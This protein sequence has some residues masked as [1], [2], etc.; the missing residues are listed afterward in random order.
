MFTQKTGYPLVLV[1]S[2]AAAAAVAFAVMV[3][4]LGNMQFFW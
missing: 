4:A 1:V 3:H 2:L